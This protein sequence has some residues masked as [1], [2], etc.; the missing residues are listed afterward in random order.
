M[1]RIRKAIMTLNGL[2]GLLIGVVPEPLEGRPTFLNDTICW[3]DTGDEDA[4]REGF[5]TGIRKMDLGQREQFADATGIPRA[6]IA[7]VAGEEPADKTRQSSEIRDDVI[8]AIA[9]NY[10]RGEE[11]T[12]RAQ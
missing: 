7:E 5:V 9:A 11:V 2:A 12:R 10:D 8:E 4:Y 6:L 3:I 1:D